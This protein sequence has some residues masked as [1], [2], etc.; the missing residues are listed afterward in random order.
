MEFS[1]PMKM[2]PCASWA[3]PFL[4]CKV[5]PYHYVSKSIAM[6]AISKY[7]YNVCYAI[8]GGPKSSRSELVSHAVSF[9]AVF[10]VVHAYHGRLS[11]KMER[12]RSNYSQA[13]EAHGKFLFLHFFPTRPGPIVSENMHLMHVLRWA[14]WQMAV[15]GCKCT[16]ICVLQHRTWADGASVYRRFHDADLR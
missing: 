9:A 16:Y 4:F 1:P 7:V 6:R 15:S 12:R 5:W 10:N 2:R 11:L 3:L 8:C 14:R 13:G